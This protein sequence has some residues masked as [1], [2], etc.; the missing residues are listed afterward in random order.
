MIDFWGDQLGAPRQWRNVPYV[1]DCGGGFV[2][3]LLC[4]TGAMHKSVCGKHFSGSNHLRKYNGVQERIAIA[5]RLKQIRS[6][7]IVI[8]SLGLKAWRD[9]AKARMLDTLT[10]FDSDNAALKFYQ[11]RMQIK[12]YLRM[13]KSSLLELALWKAKIIDWLSFPDVKS[14]REQLRLDSAKE[15]FD[16]ARLQCG[17]REI[18]PLVMIFVGEHE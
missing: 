5:A 6:E 4:G 14:A 12:K 16:R 2:V 17:C 11:E 15:Y 10:S 3:C 7:Q 1:K 9:D 13:E 8:E 18:I